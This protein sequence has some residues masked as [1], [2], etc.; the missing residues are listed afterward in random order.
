MYLTPHQNFMDAF[1]HVTPVLK[2]ILDLCRFDLTYLTPPHQ[3]FTDA[4]HHLTPVLKVILDLCRFD[5]KLHSIILLISTKRRDTMLISILVY[6]LL[7][8]YCSWHFI[9]YI[10]LVLICEKMKGKS[11]FYIGIFNL[12]I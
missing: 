7:F 2:E 4:F 1:H 8:K 10:V 6:S 9:I 3:N 12:L 5:L 11:L